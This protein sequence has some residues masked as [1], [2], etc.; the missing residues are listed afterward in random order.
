MPEPPPRPAFTPEQAEE[1][2]AK[3]PNREL[4]RQQQLRQQSAKHFAFRATSTATVVP[5]RPARPAPPPPWRSAGAAESAPRAAESG[6]STSASPGEA[7][8][9]IQTVEVDRN[10]LTICFDW[11]NTLDSALNLVG[12]YTQSIV[13]KFLDLDQ[14]AGGRVEF[15]IL[16]FSGAETGARTR[17]TAEN[18]CGYLRTVLGLKFGDVFICPD[19]TGPR[20]KSTVLVQLGAH[21]LVDDRDYICT[22]CSRTGAKTFLVYASDTLSWFPQITNWVRTEG[23]DRIIGR[24]R[25][26]ATVQSPCG[27]TN[28]SSVRVGSKATFARSKQAQPHLLEVA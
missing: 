27:K 14:V 3:D 22:E 12:L 23:V 9:R 24:H 13:D 6:S 16:S 15:H 1:A 18:L 26:V 11:H 10:N 17:N 28:L 21:A 4:R 2:L 7:R 25:A 5:P 20:G 19:P 8:V